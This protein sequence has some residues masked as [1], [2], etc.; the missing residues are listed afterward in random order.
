MSEKPKLFL[1]Y[2]DKLPID[3]IKIDGILITVKK[4]SKDKIK[5][6]Y[7][8]AEKY[9]EIVKEYYPIHF[10]FMDKNSII[11][12]KDEIYEDYYLIYRV[13]VIEINGFCCLVIPES[14]RLQALLAEA[15]II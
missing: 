13:R 12:F 8:K 1:Y 2:V 10:G 11:I 9:F 6:L 5:K 4:T 14:E 3:S 7:E 15:G